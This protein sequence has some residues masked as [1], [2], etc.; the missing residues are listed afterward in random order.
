MKDGKPVWLPYHPSRIPGLP[1]GLS[2]SYWDGSG[3]LPGDP[4]EVRFVAGIPAPGAERVLG[5][6][7]PRMRKLE[8][9]QLLS[10]GYDHMLPLLDAMPPGTRLATGRGVHREAT[11]ELALTLLLALCRGLDRFAAQQARGEWRTERRTTLAG[12]RALV[13]GYGA[14]GAAVAARLGAFRCEPVLV[15]RSART[16]P[17]GRVHGATELPALLPTVDAAVLC[18]PLTDLTRG[19]FG[20][21]ELALLKDGA[22]LVNVA[23]GEL[24]DTRAL[25]RE[26]RSGRLRA[27]LDVTDPE[28]LP[29]AHPLWNLPGALITPHV[30]AFTDAFHPATV[31][32][33]R[34]Q[35]NRY[36]RGEEPH[37]IVLTTTGGEAGE[38]AA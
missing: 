17:A 30:A 27:A 28:P 6:V 15:A 29:S 22:L 31:D 18:A 36:A 11:A 4:G 7:L 20:A 3:P 9:L 35:L 16:T 38:Q 8:V 26:V 32:F 33:L 21:E 14:V 25:V 34:R 2:Y 19:M 5:P 12:K 13:I 10:S 1:E 37:N 24:V 23:R